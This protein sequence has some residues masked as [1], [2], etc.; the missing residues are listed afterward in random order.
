MIEYYLAQAPA[1]EVMLTITDA[2]GEIIQ[3]F[4]M[5]RPA[6]LP[7]EILAGLHQAEVAYLG[8]AVRRDDAGA[9]QQHQ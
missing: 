9:R 6:A 5:R 7:S 2:G 1:G 4:G 3:Q 8:Q